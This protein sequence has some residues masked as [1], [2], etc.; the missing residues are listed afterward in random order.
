MKQHKS[1][2]NVLSILVLD[3]ECGSFERHSGTVQETR[4]KVVPYER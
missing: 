3:D 1:Q 2:P 4:T